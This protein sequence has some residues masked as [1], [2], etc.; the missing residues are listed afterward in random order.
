VI[1]FAMLAFLFLLFPTGRLCS[2]RWGPAAWFVGAVF[3]ATVV[4]MVVRATRLW[5]DP[6]GSFTEAETSAE[7]IVLLFLIVARW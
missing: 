6:F 5:Q 3:A 1:P 2:R 4:D 7:L